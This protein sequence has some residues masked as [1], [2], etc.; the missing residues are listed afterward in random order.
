LERLLE[1]AERSP[2][3]DEHAVMK[4]VARFPAVEPF[5]LWKLRDLIAEARQRPIEV[6]P[7]PHEIVAEARVLHEP[8]P[9]AMC[10]PARD[11]DHVFYREDTSEAH[12]L[13]SILHEFG[14]LCCGHVTDRPVNRGL[15]A[16]DQEWAAEHFA[17]AI[18]TRA[19][20]RQTRSACRSDQAGADLIERLRALEG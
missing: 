20:V 7:Y 8:L 10:I 5:D 14:H 18:E 13:H 16:D 3:L 1:T 9:A 4:L 11:R 12:Q 19:G 17:Y 15:Y 2:I 6:Q